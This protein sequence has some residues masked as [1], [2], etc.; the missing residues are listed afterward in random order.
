MRFNDATST[1]AKNL[2]Q[3]LRPDSVEIDG[4][5]LRDQLAFVAQFS[6]LVLYYNPQNQQQGDWQDFFLKDPAILLAA[7]SKTDYAH[8]HAQY[9]QLKQQIPEHTLPDSDCLNRLCMLLQKM[10]AS[11]NLWLRNMRKHHHKFDLLSFLS[12]KIQTQLALQLNLFVLIQQALKLKTYPELVVLDLASLSLFEREWQLSTGQGS[13]LE[14]VHS[15]LQIAELI[16]QLAGVFE[17]CFDVMVQVCDQA[18]RDFYKLEQEHCDFPDTALLRACLR[19]LEQQ[20]Q[21]NNNL[22]Q[23]HLQFYYRD[24]LHTQP[25]PAELDQALLRLTL[26][27]QVA[28]YV[29][30]ANSQFIAGSY[31][32]KSPVVFVNQDAAYLNQI[33]IAALYTEL[34]R[35]QILAADATRYSA[36]QFSR[37][38]L[39]DQ[40][41]TNDQAEVIDFPCWGNR[42]AESVPLV[43][44]LASPMLALAQ[45]QR[46]IRLEF[47]W[48]QD[49][50][51]STLFTQAGYYLS[52]ADSWQNVTAYLSQ[53][54]RSGFQL[55]L[56]SSVAAITAFSPSSKQASNTW[57][58]LKIVFAN[59][60]DM[61]I[62]RKFTRLK[63]ETQVT[64]MTQFTLANDLAT[65]ASSQTSPLFAAPAAAGANFYVHAPECF[66]KPLVYLT[67]T[68]NWDKL[69]ACLSTY[70]ASYNY[71]LAGF[72]KQLQAA[73]Y[74]MR[75]SA[76]TVRCEVRQG[77]S[78]RDWSAHCASLAGPPNASYCIMPGT[79]NELGLFAT[80]RPAPAQQDQDKQVDY[81]NL[82]ASQISLISPADF[83]AQADLIQPAVA[84][85]AMPAA[86]HLRLSLV[87]PAQGFGASLY[88][89]LVSALS[90][91]N[92]Q[93]LIQQAKAGLLSWLA[94]VLIKGLNKLMAGF[95]K[96]LGVVVAL[97]KILLAFIRRL[98]FGTQ[99]L[100]D[101]TDEADADNPSCC[102][103]QALSS[104]C[105]E[106]GLFK[107]PATPLLPGYS[108]VTLDYLARYTWQSSAT[109]QNQKLSDNSDYPFEL[110]H[111]RPSGWQRLNS[112]AQNAQL[113]APSA[114][115]LIAQPEFTNACYLA[116]SNLVLPSRLRVGFEISR[117][118]DAPGDTELQLVSYLL[119]QPQKTAVTIWRDETN[120][121]RQSGLI[122]F[123]LPALDAASEFVA[124]PDNTVWLVLVAPQAQTELR[125]AYLGTQCVRVVRQP[126]ASMP[127]HELPQ[128]APASITKL[129]PAQAAVSTIYQP[130]ASFG[131]RQAEQVT[132]YEGSH[133]YPLRLAQRL[134]NKDRAVSLKDYLSLSRQALPDLFNLIVLSPVKGRIHLYPVLCYQN[135][136]QRHALRPWLDFDQLAAY[137]NFMR[138][139]SSPVVTL[140]VAN[141][142][143]QILQ[144]AI[145]LVIA[146]ELV[147]TEFSVMLNRRLQVYLS[148]WIASTQVQRQFGGLLT[149]SALMQMLAA[150]PGVIAVE[151]LRW[152]MLADDSQSAAEVEFSSSQ[153]L[154]GD[155]LTCDQQSL[156][157][158][159]FCHQILC[160]N[161]ALASAASNQIPVL[162]QK[163]E[164]SLGLH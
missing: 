104:L 17:Q 123:D 62:V 30:P 12:Q 70:Y 82:P 61:S 24:I 27:P 5:D 131:G 36:W 142:A 117:L 161:S 128:I 120:G 150:I 39:S 132:E 20:R 75:N 78:W 38:K 89:E 164:L 9:L 87:G 10:F 151:S 45:A 4:R 126:S 77:D 119:T 44:A 136:S 79:Q 144:L 50:D 93:V 94:E 124:T 90:L 74:V 64:G 42:D 76:Y 145:E 148:P 6:R 127:Q 48:L 56:P 111:W 103:A 19:L 14:P 53:A 58:M 54:D 157:V 133:S 81:E 47:D 33:Q 25:A 63:L 51:A 109:Q 153:E 60:T 1:F 130:F 65:L 80:T 2:G 57:P 116:L 134:A 154:P 108:S 147:T 46:R 152:R 160:Q 99:N 18:G 92:A 97:I 37:I 100:H 7:I 143:P 140:S 113:N 71:Y 11:L 32:D 159:A 40:V 34:F 68:L 88:P 23:S 146:S 95:K 69:P 13:V 105:D 158:S 162:A 125:L 107:L 155:S 163:Q 83:Q 66:G 110:F 84:P 121:L 3:Q 35:P 139:R 16:R 43:L 59:H 67:L 22:S 8:Y 52:V 73:N 156:L 85:P 106:K 29:L 122:E 41:R 96:V 118:Q 129:S 115:D 101:E 102:T 114:L 49:F 137:T 112:E 149:Q 55:D 72:P 86:A 98:F 138:A 26:N 28:S 31:A 91:K 141:P 135:Q 15:E 21:I